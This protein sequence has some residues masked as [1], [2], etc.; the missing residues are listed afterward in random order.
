[1]KMS[2]RDTQAMTAQP[3]SLSRRRLLVGSA[4]AMASVSLL[5]MVLLGP[6]SMI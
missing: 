1:M 5:G 6:T 4:G 3:A 2:P